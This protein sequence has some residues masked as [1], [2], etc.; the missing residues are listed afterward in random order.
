MLSS[1]SPRAGLIACAF[2]GARRTLSIVHASPEAIRPTHVGQR[3]VDA[4]LERYGVESDLHVQCD[5]NPEE[6]EDPRWQI[7]LATSALAALRDHVTGLAEVL[8]LEDIIDRLHACEV[9]QKHLDTHRVH[10]ALYGGFHAQLTRDGQTMNFHT[11]EAA[12]IWLQLPY[13]VPA[14]AWTKAQNSTLSYK[15]HAGAS[16]R[17]TKTLLRALSDDDFA[18][19]EAFEQVEPPEPLLSTIPG[20]I[21]ARNTTKSRYKS[22]I[23]ALEGRGPDMLIVSSTEDEAMSA[24]L[25]AKQRL[26]AHSFHATVHAWSTLPETL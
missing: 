9:I 18:I 24:A 26:E 17:L 8:Y 7:P 4:V 15:R 1:S 23:F 14:S 2:Q 16:E 10:A 11:P 21:P 20:W 22:T 25:L 6:L 19:F 5:C 12:M 3:V 13:H